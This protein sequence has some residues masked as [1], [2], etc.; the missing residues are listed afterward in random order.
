MYGLIGKHLG[1]SFSSEFFN[2]KFRREG[3]KERYDLFPIDDIK[4]I[5]SLINDYPDL[6]GLNVT[7]PYK[8]EIIPFLDK[9]S[10]EAKAIGAVNVVRIIRDDTA[11]RLEGHNTDCIGFRESLLPLISSVNHK[12]ALILGTGGAAKAVDYVLSDL[13]V[14]TLFVSRKSGN[15]NITYSDLTEEIIS[16]NTLIINAT[17]LGMWPDLDSCPPIPYNFL[18][19][20]HLCYDLIYNPTETLFLRKAKAKGALIKNGFEMLKIQA[21]AAWEIWN[22]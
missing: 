19:E 18:T 15:N 5:S 22:S 13:G 21:L 10:D 16:Q 17:P 9:I 6:K 12:K 7:I 11:Y 20:N 8:E 1:H 3:L 4:K 14:T 2:N